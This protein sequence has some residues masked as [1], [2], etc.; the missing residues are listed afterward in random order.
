[1]TSHEN[2]AKWL[3]LPLLL[4]GS[5]PVD[6]QTKGV[7]VEEIVARVNNEVITREDLA[8]ARAAWKAKC[9]RMPELHPGTDAGA[10][11]GKR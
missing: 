2:Q 1:M 11:R 7:V 3:I 8:H 6:A 4:R 9:R 10:D 5:L